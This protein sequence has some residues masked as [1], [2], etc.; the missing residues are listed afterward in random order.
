M[1]ETTNSICLA[2]FFCWSYAATNLLAVA[3]AR[4]FPVLNT[5]L[6]NIFN[7]SP[8]DDTRP[9]QFALFRNTRLRGRKR[10]KKILNFL[11][12]AITPLI[13]QSLAQGIKRI[14]RFSLDSLKHFD[15]T[16]RG[17]CAFVTHI[18]FK[19]IQT[20]N[21]CVCVKK[22]KFLPRDTTVEISILVCIRG[23]V[24]SCNSRRRD[25]KYLII[26]HKAKKKTARVPRMDLMEKPVKCNR[27]QMSKRGK[28]AEEISDS[29]RIL[30]RKYWGANGP[31]YFRF[32]ACHLA[33]AR[34]IIAALLNALHDVIC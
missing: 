1:G 7:K 18:V 23:F 22:S 28:K 12:R 31:Q 16:C 30:K 6:Y 24:V 15:S 5:S 11:H 21:T 17:K 3:S 8:A 20:K 32:N 10:D 26:T 33:E 25:Y 13:N 27:N 4:I 19:I 29:F 2:N 14:N 34:K 9:E